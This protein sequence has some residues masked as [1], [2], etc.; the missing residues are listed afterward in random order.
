M[1][2]RWNAL[3]SHVRL[4]SRSHVAA[5]LLLAALLT[6]LGCGSK[7]ADRLAVFPVSGRI[8]WD[9]RPLPNAFV[10]L[11]PQGPQDLRAITA[12]G[13]TD[14]DGN[15]RVTTYEAG[16]GAPA[17]AYAVTVA[18]H[19]LITTGGGYEPGPNVLPPKYA[20]PQTTDLTVHVANGPNQLPPL[21]LRH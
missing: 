5:T 8:L 6:A 13:Q 15:F 9:G 14:Q 7:H 16:D 19:Q 11:H 4:P 20:S 21:T 17:G 12:R 1:Q 18:Y 3:V 10:V 2:N